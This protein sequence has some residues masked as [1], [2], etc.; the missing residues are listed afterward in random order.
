MEAEVI[1]AE[2]FID[3]ILA[4]MAY[5]PLSRGI[6][7]L[8]GHELPSP[9]VLDKPTIFAHLDRPEVLADVCA[10]IDR[11]LPDGEK[12]T[13]LANLGSS[14]QQVI[15]QLPHEVSPSLAGYR[16]SLFIDSAPGGLVGAVQTMRRLRAECPWDRDQTHQSLVKNLVEESFE[17]IDAISKLDEEDLVSY[18]SV[19]DEL[20]DVLLQ[21]LFHGVI[22]RERGVFDID[23]VAETMRQ[24]LVRR[25]P[26]VFG[27][28]EAGSASEVKEN[29][30]RIKAEERGNGGDRSALDD[31][32]VG[33]P[34]LGRATKIQNRAAKV[35]FDW[36]DASQVMP[37]LAEELS[38]LEAALGGSGNP[39]SELGDLLFSAVNL[40]RH[41]GLDPE[42]ALRAA[43]DRFERR[44]RRMEQ[45]GPLD[46]LDLSALDERWERAKLAEEPSG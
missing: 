43:T 30:D 10:S 5:D 2:S 22:A 1:T 8:N 20:G 3:A 12:V 26:H 45:E 23:D 9:L 27:E 46:D 14:G 32:A 35:G 19:E 18:A 28:V 34:A 31:V 36:S 25:H 33:M 7:V 13:V 16:T 21:V 4:E 39:Q 40:A 42:L 44:F 11:V 38:E 6:Q 29:W 37:K 41:L 17:L 15:E 24:K